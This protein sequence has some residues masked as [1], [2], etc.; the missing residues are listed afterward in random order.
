[1]KA[2]VIM[3][4]E[5][6]NHILVYVITL[7]LI[8]YFNSTLIVLGRPNRLKVRQDIDGL[9]VKHLQLASCLHF[10]RQEIGGLQFKAFTISLFLTSEME[11]TTE[12]G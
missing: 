10:L 7:L 9:Q 8:Y 12:T 3:K 11:V 2:D 4:L 5:I 6:N 1:M